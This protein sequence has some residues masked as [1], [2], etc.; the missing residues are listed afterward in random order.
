LT[1]NGQRLRSVYTVTTIRLIVP[2]GIFVVSSCG[3]QQSP[4][5]DLQPCSEQWLQLVEEQLTTGDTEGHGPDVGSM[6]WR[7]VVEFKLG[8]RGDPTIPPLETDEWCAYIDEKI[9]K[10]DTQPRAAVQMVD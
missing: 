8:I 7:S 4:A 6:E 2:I 10:S 5:P 9:F 3:V 1:D